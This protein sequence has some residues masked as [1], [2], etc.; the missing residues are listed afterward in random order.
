M[1]KADNLV[2]S[3][4]ALVTVRELKDDAVVDEYLVNYSNH[5]TKLWL[6]KLHVWALTNDKK[7]I[8]ERATSDQISGR[9]LFSPSA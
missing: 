1:K 6:T 4:F 3:I 8:I 7:L 9:T 5:P 2:P